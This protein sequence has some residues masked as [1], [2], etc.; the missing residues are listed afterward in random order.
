MAGMERF[1]NG[2]KVAI[3]GDR[4]IGLRGR[5][6]LDPIPDGE[7]ATVFEDYGQDSLNVMRGNGQLRTVERSNVSKA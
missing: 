1:R 4:G 3:T 5:Q 2:Q 6:T 7:V